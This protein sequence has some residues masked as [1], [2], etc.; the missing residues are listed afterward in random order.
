MSERLRI[1][2]QGASGRMGQAVLAL[3]AEHPR[4]QLAAA[5]VSTTSSSLGR[6]LGPAW[7]GLVY[8]A[9]WSGLSAFDLVIDFS[10]PAGFES[11]VNEAER[12]GAALVTGTTGLDAAAQARLDQA[13]QR[14]AVFHAANFSLGV[15]IL[16]RLLAQAARALPDWDLE[17]V[18]AHHRR[19]EDA[20]S[21]TALALG[22]Q[23]AHARGVK[24]DEVAV[25]AREGRC[26]PRTDG[27]IG[28]A[29]VR[30]GGIVGEHQALLIGPAERIELAHRA[31]DRSIFARGAVT[32]ADWL[33]LQAPG[34]YGMEELVADR[35]T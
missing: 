22:R 10:G 33:S 7:P 4:F 28:F 5:M 8:R 29:V 25:Y 3:L 35:G 17:I 23:A 31:D 2:V 13:A 30:G 18:E 14:I 16:G 6:P 19:K 1:V 11:A 12:H 15:A 34:R 27:E 26:G 9:D 21:G 24:L 20:P 32:A